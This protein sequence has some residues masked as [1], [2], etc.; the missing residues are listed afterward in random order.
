MRLERLDFEREY[1]EAIDEQE[2]AGRTLDEVAL[3]FL[4]RGDVVRLAVG[5]RTWTGRVVHVGAEVMA[6]AT[7]AG[8][9]VDVDLDA[10]SSIR[11]VERSASGG[12][13]LG[14]KHPE[15]LVARLREL[16]QTGVEV[17]LGGVELRPP[18]VGAVQVVAATHLEFRSVDGGD[19]FVPLVQVGYVVRQP[20]EG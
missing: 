20:A 5:E 2:R 17:E 10:L 12:R 13:A 1:E 18:L 7:E 6:L 19:W 3:E 4:Y 16:A 9:E 11:V 8:V 14:A 15:T